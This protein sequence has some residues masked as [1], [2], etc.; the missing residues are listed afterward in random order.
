[1]GYCV[2]TGVGTVTVC[3][4]DCSA[5]T[6][7]ASGGT[8]TYYCQELEADG[9]GAL[10]DLLDN[11][12]A[13]GSAGH[14][15]PNDIA[16]CIPSSNACSSDSDCAAATSVGCDTAQGVCLTP[17]LTACAAGGVPGQA[18]PGTI[19]DANG[20]GTANDGMCITNS[21]VQVCLAMCTPDGSTA[22]DCNEAAVQCTAVG[23]GAGVCTGL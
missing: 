22:A 21:G 1:M 11:G 5:G 17:S 18:T 6:C 2:P 20:D 10:L 23:G 9:T 7:D 13:D 16:A 8:G 3:L 12:A 15:R 14:P 4:P 19:C